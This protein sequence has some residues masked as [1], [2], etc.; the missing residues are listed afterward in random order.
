[1]GITVPCNQLFLNLS[2]YAENI[3]EIV[4]EIIWLPKVFIINR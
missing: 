3:T 4:K 2:E 1:M